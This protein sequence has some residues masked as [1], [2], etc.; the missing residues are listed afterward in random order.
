M[1]QV[2]ECL[3]SKQEALSLIMWVLSFVLLL[4]CIALIDYQ[5]LDSS[6]FPFLG[7]ILSGI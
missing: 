4:H 6:S 5:L 3:P 2:V 7:K 1:A